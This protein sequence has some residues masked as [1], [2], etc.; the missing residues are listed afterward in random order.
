MSSNVYE[1]AWSLVTG[2]STMYSEGCKRGLEAKIPNYSIERVLVVGVGGSGIVG[3]IVTALFDGYEVLVHKSFDIPAYIGSDALV[4]AVSYSGE[5]A[6]TL[7]AV[8]Q[9]LSRGMA[10][11]GIS[12]GGRLAKLLGEERVISVSSGLEPRF[13]VPEMT[14]V[15]YGLLCKIFG[16]DAVSF[17]ESVRELE[18]YLQGV[19]VE[20]FTHIVERLVNRVAVCISNGHLRPAGLRLKAQLN[21]NAKHPAYYVEMPEACHNEIEGWTYLSNFYYILH[22]RRFEDVVVKEAF[23]WAVE[24]LGGRGGEY[25]EIVVDASSRAAELLK[26]IAY[27]DLLSISLARRKGVNPFTLTNIPLLRPRL[28]RHGPKF[29]QQGD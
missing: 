18:R 24:H 13:A 23:D 19:R 4:V 22:R 2:S 5:T 7:R 26:Q 3:D 28:R 25:F 11:V 20:D 9:A 12:T 14:G 10:V 21:E 17:L 1:D 27:S 15:A 6:E 16:V 8:S 29:S